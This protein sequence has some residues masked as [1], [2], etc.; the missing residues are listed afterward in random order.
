MGI[1]C[2][3][4]A[5]GGAVE[6]IRHGE[7]GPFGRARGQG[8][9]R[10]CAPSVGGR[11][12]AVGRPWGKRHAPLSPGDTGS[13]PWSSRIVAAYAADRRA[14]LISATLATWLNYATTLVFQIL[15]AARFGTSPEAGAF[16]IAFT[17]AVS[18]AG[19]FITTATTLVMPRLATRDG[20]LSRTALRALGVG[21]AAVVAMAVVAAVIGHVR[22]PSRPGQLLRL[23]ASDAQAVLLLAAGLVAVFGLSGIVGTVALAR[24]RR[25]IPAGAHALP[26]ICGRRLSGAHAGPDS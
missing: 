10:R 18:V 15:F 12:E 2:V 24:G 23:P 13:S 9:N 1:P 21:A 7:S 4:T 14:P 5:V 22:C 3:A 19:I 8:R 20:S 16:V 6:M 17:V 25:A 11:R 26:S